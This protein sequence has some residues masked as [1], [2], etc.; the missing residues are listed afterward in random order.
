MT[1]YV[2]GFLFDLVPDNSSILT[3]SVLLIRKEKPAWQKGLYNAIGGK[4]EEGETPLEAMRREFLEET[5]LS[6]DCWEQTVTLKFKDCVVYFFRAMAEIGDFKSM[7][8]EE[9]YEFYTNKLPTNIIPN[10]NWLI[11]LNLI[12][13][14]IWPVIIEQRESE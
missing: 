10:L 1:E 6:I 4:I 8:E 9:V 5:D 12:E 3:S 13:N 2:A 11:P 7:T 14:N